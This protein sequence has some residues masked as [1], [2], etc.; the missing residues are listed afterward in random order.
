MKKRIGLLGVAI[1]I[2]AIAITSCGKKKEVFVP[3]TQ[4]EITESETQS[5]FVDAQMVSEQIAEADADT[6][7]HEVYV[8]ICGA[9]KSPG[10]YILE[11]EPRIFDAVEAAGG[12]TLD[13]ATD[14]WN[15]AGMLVDGDMIYVPTLEEAQDRNWDATQ[16]IP[17]AKEESLE[18]GI[19]PAEKET[20]DG[21]VN[22][23]T[24]DLNQLMTLSG[25]GNAKAQSIIDYRVQ[26][27][28]FMCIEDIMN[29]PGIKNGLF[30]KIKNDI[31]VE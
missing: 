1:V 17:S 18:K 19:A 27:G 30:E 7:S 9:V 13:A 6:P 4:E 26:N 23:N 10:V 29:I 21:K 12:F 2:L 11:G 20:Q 28:P 8:Y 25:V 24:A 3:A 31:T 16:A 22:I 5:E 14:Y 15:M